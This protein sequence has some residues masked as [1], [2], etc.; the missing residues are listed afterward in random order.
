[1]A[2]QRDKIMSN[3]QFILAYVDNQFFRPTRAMLDLTGTGNV[4]VLIDEQS[5]LWVRNAQGCL[6]R[7]NDIRGHFQFHD[8]R[9]HARHPDYVSSEELRRELQRLQ[10]E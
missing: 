4:D 8:L 1:V 3:T 9:Q 7:I 5:T 6:L 10:N 2:V